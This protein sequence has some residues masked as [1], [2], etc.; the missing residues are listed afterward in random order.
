GGDRNARGSERTT[1]KARAGPGHS[2]EMC[3]TGA[4]E[5]WPDDARERNEKGW[6]AGFLH[7][8][9]VSFKT[10]DEHQYEAANLCHEQQS[11]GSL[12][13]GKDLLVKKIQGARA[14]NYSDNELPKNGRNVDAR[15]QRRAQLPCRE[16]DGDKQRELQS[17]RHE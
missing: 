14:E 12:T 17:G 4:Q 16:Q 3:H 13:A 9:N 11:V 15:E 8:V 1:K 2:Q 10:S 6:K 7:A 5:E